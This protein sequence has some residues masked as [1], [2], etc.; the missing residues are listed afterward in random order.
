MRKATGYALLSYAAAQEIV[1]AAKTRQHSLGSN[2]YT[3]LGAK[4]F[5]MA[6]IPFTFLS[7]TLVWPEVRQAMDEAAHYFVDIVQLQRAVGKR[8]AEISGAE[9]GMITS[10]AAGAMATATAA[11]IAGSDP[12]KIWR[13]PD[14]SGMKN[15]VL[16]WGGRSIFDNAIRLAGGKLIVVKTLDELRQAISSDTAM[17]YAGYPAD[18]K[19]QNA[20]PLAEIVALCHGRSSGRS[21]RPETESPTAISVASCSS[22]FG[23]WGFF[24][25][26]R[27]N[28]IALTLSPPATLISRVGPGLEP[29]LVSGIGRKDLSEDFQYPFTVFSRYTAGRADS[30][31]A[32]GD[33]RGIEERS[34][35][36]PARRRGG[37]DLAGLCRSLHASSLT[38]LRHS[39]QGPPATAAACVCR[40]QENPHRVRIGAGSQEWVD[41]RKISAAA[42][43]RRRRTAASPAG[44]RAPLR[45]CS[46]GARRAGQACDG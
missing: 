9:S 4:P 26:A 35:V 33:A 14:S 11:C 2:V 21:M 15:E 40:T 17:L 12:D 31:P 34:P 20:S 25:E 38:R 6:N 43:R 29:S 44:C 24:W 32:P 8:L 46:P 3:R 22:S 19:P 37:R 36:P 10:G 23:S 5:I 16:M 28:R 7:A 39:P 41:C 30:G 13:L 18:P 45:A 27:S 1:A 42:S